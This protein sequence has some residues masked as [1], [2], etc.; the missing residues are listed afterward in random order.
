VLLLNSET[1][2]FID[3]IKLKFC[4]LAFWKRQSADQ[5]PWTP[6]LF[7]SSLDRNASPY[8]RT[9]TCWTTTEVWS[10]PAVWRS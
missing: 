1:D 9:F 3:K 8:E 10:T 2:R 6:S 4:C 7:A 5:E